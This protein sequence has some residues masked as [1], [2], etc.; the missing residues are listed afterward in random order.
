MAIEDIK[1]LRIVY[2]FFVGH[3]MA[4]ENIHSFCTAKCKF[5]DWLS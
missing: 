5:S 4:S 1:Y 3:S 2:E